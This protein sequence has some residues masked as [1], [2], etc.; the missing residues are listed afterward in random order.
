[1]SNNILVTGGAGYIGSHLVRLLLKY[2][3]NVVVFDNFSRGHL[4]LIEELPIKIIEG[5][6]RNKTD[7]SDTFK[8]NKI[9]AVIHLAALAY[10][11]EST[12]KPEMY[13]QNNVNGTVNLLAAMNSYDVKK[14]VFSSTCA[15]YGIPETLPIT[16]N[17]PLSPINPY[18]TSK[19]V[20]EEIIQS[21]G[22]SYTILRYFNV[23][24]SCPESKTGEWH[25]P[26]T[27][28]IPLALQAA[29]NSSSFSIYGDDFQTRD[30][31][32]IRDYIHVM[33][34]AKAH[35][36]AVQKL[37]KET[38]LICNLG[39]QKGYSV[40]EILNSVQEITKSKLSIKISDRRPGDPPLLTA[41][42]NTALQELGWQPE[43]N[44][45]DSIN[46]ALKWYNSEK[47]HKLKSKNV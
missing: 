4:E 6:L 5:D 29:A 13:F 42:S 39:T 2:D 23:C 7:I 34:L 24:G 21:C 17:S 14:I 43:F 9:D 47:F 31:S 28:V 12:Q 16:E 40:K 35:V 10:V 37:Q 18:G 36:L 11:G 20:C 27:H 32:C 46:H 19:K 33:D 25:E 44:L 8:E 38:S 15:V 1:M 3:F 45:H 41:N 30:G 26:E 22:L